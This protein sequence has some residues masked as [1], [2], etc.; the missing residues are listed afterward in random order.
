MN[1]ADHNIDTIFSENAISGTEHCV[2]RIRF[3]LNV[4]VEWI[5]FSEKRQNEPDDNQTDDDIDISNL[6]DNGL[7]GNYR[8]EDVLVDFNRIL[9]DS[10][11]LNRDPDEGGSGIHIGNAHC[12]DADCFIRRR[13]Q[14]PKE[15]YS[16]HGDQMD[17][18]F[19][20]Q[21]GDGAKSGDGARRGVVLQQ[22]LDSIH[23]YLQHRDAIDMQQIIE[24][25]DFVDPQTADLDLDVLCKDRLVITLDREGD[26]RREL[27]A[28]GRLNSFNEQNIGMEQCNK[29]LV[30]NTYHRIDSEPFEPSF[31][32]SEQSPSENTDEMLLEELWSD[33]VGPDYFECDDCFVEQLMVELLVHGVRVH[34]ISNLRHF[35]QSECFDTDSIIKDVEGFNDGVS[36]ILNIFKSEDSVP[37]PRENE[38]ISSSSDIHRVIADFIHLYHSK[39]SIISSMRYRFYYWPYYDGNHGA[40]YSFPGRTLIDHNP[41]YTLSDWYIEC[42]YS[43]FKLEILSNPKCGFSM[44]DW[45]ET[46]TKSTIKWRAYRKEETHRPLQC[47]AGR[48]TEGRIMWMKEAAATQWQHVY[49]IKKGHTATIPHLMALLFYM[50]YPRACYEFLASFRKIVWNETDYSLKQRHSSFAHQGRL[51]RELVECF[52][53]T[54]SQCTVKLFHFGMEHHLNFTSSTFNYCAPLSTTSGLLFFLLSVTGSK[55]IKICTKLFSCYQMLCPHAML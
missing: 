38:V 19:F 45:I 55:M 14:R 2:D 10:N 23:Y 18:L 44:R 1:A 17:I 4:Y 36:S 43:S 9:K 26:R 7:P 22:C 53:S 33:E 13:H 11:L 8:F 52:G 29:F 54:M 24:N 49:G 30:T 20:L 50:N 40:Y 31:A 6:M 21:S 12:D 39:V 16:Q 5:R 47:G 42:K 15:W 46:M 37:D 41:G 27:R 25:L 35:I 32:S 3:V 28:S 51:L 48:D 34:S